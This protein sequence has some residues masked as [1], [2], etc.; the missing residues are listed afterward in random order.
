M[1]L[2]ESI[3][4]GL[5][6][7][8]DHENGRINA[9]TV[10]LSVTPIPDISSEEIRNIRCSAGL[11][12]SLFAEVFGVSVKTVEAWEHGTNKPIGPARRMLSL[13]KSDPALISKYNIIND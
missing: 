13:I 5:Q 9:K 3:M 10:R 4:T 6:E 2:F 7:A 12:Q 1:N 8:A 11:T